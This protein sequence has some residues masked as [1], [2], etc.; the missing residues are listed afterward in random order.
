MIGGILGLIAEAKVCACGGGIGAYDS[1]DGGFQ[2][3][4]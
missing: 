1:E 3:R 4:D 2:A